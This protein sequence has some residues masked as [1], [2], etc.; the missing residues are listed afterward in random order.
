M[1]FRRRSKGCVA[2]VFFT[3]FGIGVVVVE[4]GEDTEFSSLKI[5]V[6]RGCVVE[7]EPLPQKIAAHALRSRVS[8]RTLQR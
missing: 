6:V 4:G 2:A 5:V 1:S 7:I 8:L 3:G